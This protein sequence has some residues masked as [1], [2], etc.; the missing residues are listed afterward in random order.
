MFR[1]LCG[2]IAQ[3]ENKELSVQ[4]IKQSDPDFPE[5]LQHIAQPP[6]CLYILGAHLSEILSRPRIAIVGSRKISAYGRAVT[7][8]LAQ[9]LARLGIVVLS[10]LAFG[11][12]SRAH[13]ATLDAGG[14]TA[15]VL[16]CGVDQV[17]PASHQHLANTMLKQGGAL[18]S[19]YPPGTI[20]YK[21]HFIARNRLISALAD[22]VVITEAAQ[23]SGSLHTAQFALEQGK[24]VFAVPGN[25]TSETSAGTNTLIKSGAT[26]VTD[27]QD[28]L[29]PLGWQTLL[30][31]APVRPHGNTPEEQ[32][33]L[34]LIADGHQDGALLLAKSELS[35]SQFN[36]TL[37]ML[38]VTDKIYA[39][40]NNQWLLRPG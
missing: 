16:A 21:H 5:I 27:L 39:A 10:G 31:A 9:A 12:D 15:A 35:I 32:C 19:E 29:L 2:I 3:A 18:I 4:I 8:R 34:D 40:G 38:E 13:Q 30:K 28:I 22:G 25:I 14:V 24:E 6:Q 26:L 1:A 33:L 37:T 36:Q 20:P 23:K 17:Y 11:V 7:E